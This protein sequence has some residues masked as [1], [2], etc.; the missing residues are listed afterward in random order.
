MHFEIVLSREFF[1]PLDEDGREKSV[2][3]LNFR[4]RYCV[5][6][7][8]AEKIFKCFSTYEK[9][10]KFVQEMKDEAEMAKAK[11]IKKDN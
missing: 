3:A 8:G 10:K 11:K 1:F 6:E 4:M 9:A 2:N 5:R 7:H